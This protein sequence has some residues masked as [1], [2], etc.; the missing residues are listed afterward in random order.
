M[1]QEYQELERSNF[2]RIIILKLES[3]LDCYEGDGEAWQLLDQ[4][5]TLSRAI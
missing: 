1:W 2:K 3:C 5:T 4:F